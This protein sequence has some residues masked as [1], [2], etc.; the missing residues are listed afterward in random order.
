MDLQQLIELLRSGVRVVIAMT[1]GGAIAAFAV[2]SLLPTTFEGRA[3]LIAPTMA[4]TY[5]EVAESRPVLEHVIAGLGLTVTADELD[6]NVDALPSQTSALLV[7]TARDPVATRAADI[8]NAIADRLVELAPEISGSSAAAQQA[9][10]DDLATVQRE[11]T[12]TEAA[13]GVLAAQPELTPEDRALLAAHHSQLASLLT[14]RVSLQNAVLS[15][16]QTVVTVLAPAAPPTQPSSPKVVLATIAGGFAGLVIGL[17]LVL[18]PPFVRTGS[19]GG[20]PS[21]EAR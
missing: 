10:Q 5:A 17:G 11:I 6:E 4:S 14:L 15:Y 8:A 3:S 20:R 1:L 21:G 19:L 18:I 2:S 13:I 9:L 7:I 12:R 16:A